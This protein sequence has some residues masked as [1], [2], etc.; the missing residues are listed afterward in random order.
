MK[1]ESE[2]AHKL[3]QVQF[4]HAKKEIN[5]LVAVTPE[6]CKHNRRL[7][8]NGI[9]VGFCFA[10]GCPNEGQT[11]D[12]RFGNPSAKCGSYE[13]IFTA[14]EARNKAKEFFKNS[15]PGEIA[16]KYP[17]VAA[18]TWTL[19]DTRADYADPYEVGSLGGVTLWADSL[20]NADR[21]RAALQ[22]LLEEPAPTPPAAPEPPSLSPPEPSV[23]LE[24]LRATVEENF[25]K[26]HEAVK[27][28]P[29]GFRAF[30]ISAWFIVA[31][32]WKKT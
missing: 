21:A 6:N 27:P 24:R 17:D 22:A 16:A 28:R 1:S 30:L 9:S 3:K 18:L 19:D 12:F 15:S 7:S 31:S 14:E 5:H 25:S 4:R 23:E 10:S 11:C 26:L 20:G 2:I 32:L 8:L 29:S 13:A